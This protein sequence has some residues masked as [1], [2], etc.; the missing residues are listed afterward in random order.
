M[1]YR[2]SAHGAPPPNLNSIDKY[3]LVPREINTIEW[4]PE[5]SNWKA[6]KYSGA[7]NYKPIAPVSTVIKKTYG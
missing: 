1:R 7:T 5:G 6:I 2:G 3:Q 4:V